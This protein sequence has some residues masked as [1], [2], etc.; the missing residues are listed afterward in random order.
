MKRP[1]KNWGLLT[2]LQSMFF[3]DRSRHGGGL[4]HIANFLDP[5]LMKRPVF[6]TWSTA[7]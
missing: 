1:Q 6:Y 3:Q 5:P 4:P 2:I 7:S